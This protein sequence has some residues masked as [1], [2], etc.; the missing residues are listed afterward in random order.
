MKTR[1]KTCRL[2]P[3]LAV[4]VYDNVR[5]REVWPPITGGER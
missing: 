5:M 1:K 3:F 4:V 2:V